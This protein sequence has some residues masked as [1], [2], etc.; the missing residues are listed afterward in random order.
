MF[1]NFFATH[2]A[3]SQTESQYEILTA[4]TPTAANPADTP[5]SNTPADTQ[6]D[7]NPADTQPT[8]TS[9]DTKKV[10]FFDV[11]LTITNDGNT[12]IKQFKSVDEFD[13]YLAEIRSSINS[14]R[15]FIRPDNINAQTKPDV[16]ELDKKID[17]CITK[18]KSKIIDFTEYDLTCSNSGQPQIP[19][20]GHASY[21]LHIPLLNTNIFAKN[22]PHRYGMT[23]KFYTVQYCNVAPPYNGV[24]TNL[25][26]NDWI[27]VKVIN[28]ILDASIGNS[29]LTTQARVHFLPGT[30][31]S[32][33]GSTDT[34]LGS[35]FVKTFK[36]WLTK[37]FGT[38]V[39]WKRVI[40]FDIDEMGYTIFF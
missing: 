22:P 21:E 16:K 30:Y 24:N 2:A 31:L 1:A 39:S 28:N 36:H 32:M 7:T 5:T 19:S 8:P 35:V 20:V 18:D 29:T 26:M 34:I 23:S 37:E 17:E 15:A 14:G 33:S 11:N 12:V 10:R 9:T 38:D 6:P 3:E 27:D 13:A 25:R 4:D 40:V